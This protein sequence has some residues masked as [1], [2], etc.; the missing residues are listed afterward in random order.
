MVPA[1]NEA[2]TTACD[3]VPRRRAAADDPDAPGPEPHAETE[4]GPPEEAGYGYGV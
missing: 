1:T 3:D 2:T 4:D